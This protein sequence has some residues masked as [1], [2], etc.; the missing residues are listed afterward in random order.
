[1]PVYDFLCLAWHNGPLNGHVSLLIRDWRRQRERKRREALSQAAQGQG[2]GN[3]LGSEDQ[4]QP[5]QAHVTVDDDRTLRPTEAEL[6]MGMGL[7]ALW[8]VCYNFAWA[9][10]QFEMEQ[11][12]EQPGKYDWLAKPLASWSLKLAMWVGTRCLYRLWQSWWTGGFEGGRG[13]GSSTLVLFVLAFPCAVLSGLF[14]TW[15]ELWTWSSLLNMLVRSM[16]S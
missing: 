11:K 2:Q 16:L 10:A 12:G 1:M 6:A 8:I 15:E 14:A 7:I 13:L 3:A 9:W 5:D 4:N